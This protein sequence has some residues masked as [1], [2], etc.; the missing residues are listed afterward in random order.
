MMIFSGSAIR[1]NVF[2]ESKPTTATKVCSSPKPTL[3]RTSEKD[4]PV[5]LVSTATIAVAPITV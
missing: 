2:S 1:D 4:A 3:T 5:N